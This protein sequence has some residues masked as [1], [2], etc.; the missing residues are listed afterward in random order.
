MSALP[1]RAGLYFLKFLEWN[2][3][4][5]ITLAMGLALRILAL[6]L[7]SHIALRNEAFGYM[8][9]A[10]QLLHHQNFEPYWP[11]GVPYYLYLVQK[12]FGESILMAR[13]AILPIYVVFTAILYLL[14]KQ[15]VTLRAANLAAFIFVFYPPYVRDSFNPSTEYP[16]AAC[17][18]GIVLFMTIAERKPS[19]APIALTGLALGAL[20]LIRPSSLLVAA[21][22]CY[23]LFRRLRSVKIAVAPLVIAAILV[24]AWMWKAYTLTG[25]FVAINDSNSQNLFWGNN[26]YTPL[27]A[28]WGEAQ[29]EIGISEGYRSLLA[30]I[31]RESPQA[32]DRLYTELA[33]DHIRSR[34]D[35]FVLRTLNRARA[36]FGF[37]V[38]YGEPLKSVLGKQSRMW[39]AILLT[40]A[41]LL[42]YWALM[43]LAIVFLFNAE[44]APLVSDHRLCLLGTAL[45]YALPYWVSISQPRYNF[46]VVPLL[47]VFA[48]TLLDFFL[49]PRASEVLLPIRE[50]ARR[51]Y[52]MLLVLAAFAYIQ[53]EWIYVNYFRLRG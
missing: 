22:V 10:A 37:P 25:R 8:R 53:I 48:V 3:A 33:L 14:M 13:A 52:A 1:N 42:F 50:S 43:A 49:Q 9:M 12:L 7:V 24:S 32:R 21:F 4:I 38:H 11:P 28:T 26:P 5:Y 39:A 29:G 44:E 34:P 31:D 51:R 18:M 17:V 47:A 2:R 16:A 36:Y 6:S 30:G 15:V 19:F 20:I 41:D 45:A 40:V 46:P 35:L 23:Y 27:Y